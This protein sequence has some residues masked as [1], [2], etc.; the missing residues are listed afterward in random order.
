MEEKELN[1]CV[2]RIQNAFRKKIKPE[3]NKRIFLCRVKILKM[4]LMLVVIFVGV[5]AM[6]LKTLSCFALMTFSWKASF[7]VGV[8]ALL[9]W[10]L[11]IHKS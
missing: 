8:S 4:L 11:F 2:D 10:L 5:S 3:L 7:Y 1:E 9:I 6:V